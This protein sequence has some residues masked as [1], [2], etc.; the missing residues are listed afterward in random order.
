[1]TDIRM[2]PEG[3][4]VDDLDLSNVHLHGANLGGSRFT[5]AYLCGAHISGDIEGLRVNDVDIEPLVRAELDRRFPDRV[6]L[7]ATD[8]EGLREAWSMLEDLWS[9][10]TERASRLPEELQVQRVG[11]EW[12]FVETL[13]HLICATD[14]WLFRA[15]LLTPRPYHPW[16]LLW[17]GVGPQG[18]QEVGLDTSAMPNLAA[19]LPVRLEHQHA[20]RTALED[21]TDGELAEVRTAPEEPGH[22]RGE[23]SVLHCLHVLLN[24]EWEHHGYA[25]RD[26]AILEG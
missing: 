5:D 6:K 23:H 18:A 4:R 7:R 13:R 20:V 25:Q 26:L 19:V 17:S 12:S 10:T 3:S 11:G 8:S 14:C 9:T 22:P 15:I 21:L 2:F 16:G 24:E 1:M